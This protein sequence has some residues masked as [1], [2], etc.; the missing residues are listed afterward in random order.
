MFSPIGSTY[1]QNNY[2][3]GAGMMQTPSCGCNSF[4]GGSVFGIGFNSCMPSYSNFAFPSFNFSMPSFCCNPYGG[5]SMYSFAMMNRM[6][7]M[8]TMMNT[9]QTTTNIANNFVNSFSS[10]TSSR[11]AAS[12]KSAHSAYSVRNANINTNTGLTSLKN[13]GYNAQKG[14]ELAKSAANNAIGFSNQCAKYVRFALDRTGL[15]NGLKGD[16]CDYGNILSQN[17]NFKEISSKGLNLS[18]LPAGCILVYDRG[19]SGYSRQYGHV[20]ITLGNGQ[21]VSDGV[22]NN[23]RNGARVFVPV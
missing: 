15:G 1:I 23:I 17:K 2:F 8:F 16:G 13:A 9:L 6:M 7:D 22:T 21:A 4:Y 10:L 18:S 3:G 5:Y 12:A 14:G 11:K 20:E 19:V